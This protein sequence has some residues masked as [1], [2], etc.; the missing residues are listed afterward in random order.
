MKT[1][2]KYLKIVEWSEK[3]GCYI[4][5]CPGLLHG[6]VHGKNEAQVYAELCQA[7]E[8]ALALYQADRKPLPAATAGKRYS[9]KFLLRVGKDLHQTMAVRALQAGESLNN[10]CQK[11]LRSSA[12]HRAA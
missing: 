3:D 5:T 11:I 4:G 6:G 12:R 1:A 9:G 7:V 2:D 10:Y 8:E